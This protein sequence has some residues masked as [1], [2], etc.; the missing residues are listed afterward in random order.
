L[1]CCLHSLILAWN[2]SNPWYPRKQ[3]PVCGVAL[4]R[5]PLPN[6][7]H[8]IALLPLLKLPLLLVLAMIFLG[9][10]DELKALVDR[11]ACPGNWEHKGHFEMF[12]CEQADTNLKLNWWPQSGTLTIVGDPA[13]REEMQEDLARLLAER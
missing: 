13:E 11:L 6:H 7:L 3:N 5:S 4:K 10:L 2:C 9:T 12:V 8:A 1:P